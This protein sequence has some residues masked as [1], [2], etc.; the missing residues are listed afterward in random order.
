MEPAT[1]ANCGIYPFKRIENITR[2]CVSIAPQFVNLD[3]LRMRASKGTLEILAGETM[4]CFECGGSLQQKSGELVC[5]EC[6]VVWGNGIFEKDHIPFEVKYGGSYEGHWSPPNELA[7]NRNL[8]T[9]QWVSRGSFC[10]IIVP[11]DKE[12]LGLRARHLK[13]LTS[14]VEHPWIVNMLECGS[15]LCNDFDLHRKDSVC[16]NFSNQ[17]GRVLR[18]LGSFIIHRG[19]HWGELKKTARAAFVLLYGE[20]AGPKKAEEARLQLGV[21]TQFLRY[22]RFLVDMLTPRRRKEKKK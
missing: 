20:L 1:I 8:G 3:F 10:R 2:L 14:T 12:D 11:I 21:D 4:L 13:T 18:Q 15:K 5:K 16:I 7:F 9:N 17:Y 19:K 22:V 6:G